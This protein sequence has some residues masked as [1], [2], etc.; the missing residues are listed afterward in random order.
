LKELAINLIV[1]TYIDDKR[2]NMTVMVMKKY[3]FVNFDE[4]NAMK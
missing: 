4:I 2:I 1:N 3:R